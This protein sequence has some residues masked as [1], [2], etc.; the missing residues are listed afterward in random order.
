MDAFNT[1]KLSNE[2]VE[3]ALYLPDGT[4]TDEFLVVRG[5]DSKAFR[6]AQARANRE[7]VDIAK[8]KDLSPEDQATKAAEVNTRLVA[9]LVADWS[10]SQECNDVN[11]MKFL[12][13]APQIQ[14]QVDV[15]A[16]KHSNF[17]TKPPQD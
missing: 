1:A 17:F 10:F 3:L 2:G 9:S 14:R 6:S 8:D 7:R 4:K 15:F 12:Q 5:M 11:K 13:D 16:E